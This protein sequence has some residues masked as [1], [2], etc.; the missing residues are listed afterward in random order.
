MGVR[1]YDPRQGRFVSS[2]PAAGSAALTSPLQRERWLYAI[3]S[4]LVYSDP[5]GMYLLCDEDTACF[6]KETQAAP[7]GSNTQQTPSTSP[8]PPYHS[9]GHDDWYNDPPTDCDQACVDAAIAK[10]QQILAQQAAAKAKQ[11]TCDWWDAVCKAK[12]AWNA[13]T[14]AVGDAVN[15]C[16]SSDI[17]K[18]VVTIGVGIAVFAGCEAITA[19]VG[20]LGCAVAAGAV[21]GAVS[22]ALDCKSGQSMAG[23]VAAGAAIGAVTGLVGGVAGRVVAAVG[24]KIAGAVISRL[25]SKLEAGEENTVRDLAESCAVNSFAAGTLVL[26]ADGTKKPIDQIQPGD[27]VMAGDPQTGVQR[28][29]AVKRVIVGRGL[30]HLYDIHV[31]GDVIEATYNHPF[32]VVELQTF[33][34]AQDLV[35]GEHLLLADGRAPPITSISHHDE[36]TTVYNLSI[37]SIHT[38]YVGRIGALVH[39]ECIPMVPKGGGESRVALNGRNIHDT[40]DKGIREWSQTDSRFE[41]GLKS[42]PNRPDAFFEKQPVELKPNSPSGIAAGRAQLTRYKGA[43]GAQR[44]YLFTYDENGLIS[45]HSII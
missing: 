45:L 12:Q 25:A 29:E 23:C 21:S 37:L 44:G 22:G 1:W 10:S 35:P 24:G 32:W 6:Y 42:G 15:F 19:G 33:V 41:P 20:S 38:F 5:T 4:P 3:D 39:N 30:K 7:T 16:K 13:T 17:C 14:K 18:T 34:W 40:F 26:M 9:S 27:V 28:A 31:D 2:D 11:K 8:P 43:F 36:I